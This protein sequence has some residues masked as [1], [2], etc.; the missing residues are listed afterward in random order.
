MPWKRLETVD[1]LGG[2]RHVFPLF[3]HILRSKL[4]IFMGKSVD[5]YFD[6][7]DKGGKQCRIF[8]VFPARPIRPVDNSPKTVDNIL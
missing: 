7:V 4:W 1:N 8:P 2:N 3:I 5:N 6:P